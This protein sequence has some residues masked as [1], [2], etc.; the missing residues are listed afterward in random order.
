MSPNFGFILFFSVHLFFILVQAQRRRFSRQS[1]L[2]ETPNSLFTTLFSYNGLLSSI[3]NHE[4]V[5][6]GNYRNEYDYIIVGAGS[7]GSVL[8]NRLSENPSSNVLLLEAGGQETFVNGVPLFSFFLQKSS[9]DWQYQSAPLK[10]AA[11]GLINNSIPIPRG[12]VIGGTSAMNFMMYV[13]GNKK[14]YNNWEEMGAKGWSWKDVFPYFIKSENSQVPN[15]EA[16]YHGTDG[17]ISV[18]FAYH[19][20]KHDEM[21]LQAAQEMNQTLGDINGSNQ[22]RFSI[23]PSSVENGSRCSTGYAYLVPASKRTNLHI[24][25]HSMVKTVIFNK[26]KTAIGVEFVKDNTTFK[27]YS[28]K[29]VILSAGSI[30]TPQILMLSGIGP[31]K[32]LKKMKIPMIQN[33]PGVGENLQDH[34]FTPVFFTSAPHSELEFFKILTPSVFT[35]YLA[36]KSGYFSTTGVYGTGFYKTKYAEDE[37]PDIQ[38]LYLSY[39]LTKSNAHVAGK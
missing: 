33:L 4:F 11:R 10:H 23:V 18:S 5:A 35:E 17:P 31:K 9:Q 13:R 32:H 8:A 1:E 14:D 36:H 34:P 7:A 12:K 19:D 3:Y 15:S 30:N 2:S 27:V 20:Q 22:M 28:S 39:A 29:E 24:S 6:F 16:G 38:I 26:N 37:R 21:L 25:I